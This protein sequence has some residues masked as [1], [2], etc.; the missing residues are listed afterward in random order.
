MTLVAVLSPNSVVTDQGPL[1]A[2]D[3]AL[4]AQS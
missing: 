1:D 2:L 3:E 4:E